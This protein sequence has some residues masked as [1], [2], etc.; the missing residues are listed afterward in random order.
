MKNIGTVNDILMSDGIKNVDS[1]AKLNIMTE[2]NNDFDK[3]VPQIMLSQTTTGTVKTWNGDR[4]TI[5]YASGNNA[6]YFGISEITGSYRKRLNFEILGANN[7]FHTSVGGTYGNSF[8]YAQGNKL[9]KNTH[10]CNFIHSDYNTFNTSAANSFNFIHS[11]N[12]TFKAGSY[13]NVYASANNISLY[14]SND[15][16]FNPLP[17]TYTVVSTKG[18]TKGQTERFGVK[19][20]FLRN[21]TLIGS[22][23]NYIKG[24]VVANGTTNVPNTTFINSNSG[25]YDFNE[26]HGSLTFIGN[27]FGYYNNVSGG[28]VIGIGEGLIQDGGSSDKILL[29]FYNQ[30]T[31]DPNEVLVVGDGRLNRSYVKGLTKNY[32]DDWNT[33]HGAWNKIMGSISGTGSTAYNDT[34]Y[35]HNIFTVNKQGYVTISDYQVP[36]NSARY[37][38]KGIT[39]YVDGAVYDIPFAKVYNKINGNDAVDI[40][41]ETID[42]YTH[43]IQTRIDSMPT[44]KFETFTDPKSIVNTTIQTSGYLN[45]DKPSNNAALK[46]IKDIDTYTN[47]SIIGVS[48]Q[49]DT[50]G[51]SKRRIPAKIVWSYYPPVENGKSNKVTLSTL[52]YPYCTKQFILRK[53]YYPSTDKQQK[54]FSGI[55][56]VESDDSTKNINYESVTPV[57]NSLKYY[58]TIN[59]NNTVRYYNGSTSTYQNNMWIT[60]PENE[61]VSTYPSF[62]AK[63]T[64]A[65]LDTMNTIN[66]SIS[67]ERGDY[68]DVNYYYV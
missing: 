20:C 56:L 30:N 7:V 54:P 62:T 65:S 44:T 38:Y 63:W 29:G 31:T 60:I 41:Q 22:N 46:I 47:N 9:S 36:S 15:N 28:N 12:N 35:R 19:G 25:L 59:D 2:A 57:T 6:G 68:A 40:M 33:K 23:F 26:H 67:A 1:I 4:L 66:D 42:S 8:I 50:I 43:T 16:T 45:L 55:T 48:Y 27:T 5:N 17:A 21:Q 34:H 58:L 51:N 14:N 13:D 3:N 49:P 10:D 39:A 52:I 18:S 11:H 24:R 61:D 32:G 53:P 64:T 37:G